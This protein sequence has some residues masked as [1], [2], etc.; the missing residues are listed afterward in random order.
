MAARNRRCTATRLWPT[1]GIRATNSSIWAPLT[2][3]STP[4]SVKT[5]DRSATNRASE[6]EEKYC[7]D[8]SNRSVSRSSTGTVMGRWSFS[9]WLT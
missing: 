1:S 8:R 5:S 6:S 9:N 7:A 3:C 2:A 4:M